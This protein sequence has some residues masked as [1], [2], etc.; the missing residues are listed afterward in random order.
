[1]NI[2]RI[3]SEF[4][5]SHPYFKARKDAYQ[6]P[7]GKIVDPYFV[8]ELPP[9]VVVMALTRENE[10]ILVRQY[11]YPVDEVLLELP[12]GFIEEG[13]LPEVAVRRELREETGYDFEQFH[14]LGQAGGNPGV[15]NNF[16]HFYLAMDGNRVGTQ[17]LD[18]NEEIEVLLMPL[19]KL[20]ETLLQSGIKQSL[21]ALCLF[22]GLEFLG[23]KEVK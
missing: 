8:V 6:L 22:F 17:S 2:R 7:G 19:E 5:S 10:V 14:Y 13:E 18:P 12:G 16:T 20:K 23:R 4:L 1:M 15:L 9:C 21:H 11:R 3:R